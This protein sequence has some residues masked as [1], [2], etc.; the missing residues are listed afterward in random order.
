MDD[1]F[2][3]RAYFFDAGIL[4]FNDGCAIYA[5]RPLQFRAFPFGFRNR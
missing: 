4:F 5:A 1:P 2:A 3:P